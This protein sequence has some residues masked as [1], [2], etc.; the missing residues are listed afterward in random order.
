MELPEAVAAADGE[1]VRPDSLVAVAHRIRCY[2]S[3]VVVDGGAAAAH[4]NYR[5]DPMGAAVVGVADQDRQER[6]AVGASW[7]HQ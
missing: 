2:G 3:L 4:R 5:R 7:N 6:Q 1:L